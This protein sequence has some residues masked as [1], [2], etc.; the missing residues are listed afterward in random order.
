MS[1][2]SDLLEA[3]AALVDRYEELRST[4]LGTTVG[5][6]AIRGL[7]VLMHKGMATWI[8][9]W[10][11]LIETRAMPD[12]TSKSGQFSPVYPEVVTMLAEMTMSAAREVS[13]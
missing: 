11:R 3:D 8:Q 12:S 9:T 13:R 10:S 6:S 5:T 1:R 7:A 2:N 4:A